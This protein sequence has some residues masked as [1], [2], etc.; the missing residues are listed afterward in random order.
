[1]SC[2]RKS[3]IHF[4]FLMA[5]LLTVFTCVEAYSFPFREFSLGDPVPE[6][7]LQQST[8]QKT[9]SFSELKGR[10]FITVFWG[11]DLPA[12]MKRSIQTLQEI[13]SLL[14]FLQQR[15]ILLISVNIQGDDPGVIQGVVSESKSSFPI[16][17]DLEKQV[18]GDLG[19]FVMPTILLVDKEGKARSGLGYRPDMVDRLKGEV[20][21]MLGEKTDEQVQ[22]EL[23]PVMEEKSSEEKTGNLHFNLGLVMAQRGL[24][25][26]A[27]R[28]FLKALEINPEKEQAHIELGCLYLE[29]GELGK[30][31]SEIIQGLQAL[32]DS[33]PGKICRGQILSQKG[34]P[35]EAIKEF[36]ALIK[37][38]PALPEIYYQLGRAFEKQGKV[39]VAMTTMKKA[40]LMLLKKTVKE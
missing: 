13:E 27:I 22:A 23:Y 19:I 12:K 3:I 14:P 2:N 9:V 35:D 36:K 15:D 16:F 30:A 40:Y 33:L 20:E 8:D 34:Q 5:S 39:D 26:N 28:E 4:F 11:A 10:P 32:P 17:L 25:D 1:M 24:P 29:S 38:F 21:I 31:E 37:D 18:Y 6:V 7:L